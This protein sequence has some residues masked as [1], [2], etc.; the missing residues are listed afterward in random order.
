MT[1]FVTLLGRKSDPGNGKPSSV[2]MPAPQMPPAAQLPPVV[3]LPTVAPVQ[4]TPPPLPANAAAKEPEIDLDNDLFSPDAAQ[5]GEENET[6]RGLL[7]DAEQKIG[8]LESVK[9]SIAK[10]VDPVAS[11]LR[12]YE[13]TKSEKLI[14]QRALSTARQAC[15]KLRDDLAA[16]EKKAATFKAECN[17]LQDIASTAKQN[18]ATLER[19]KTELLAELAVQRTHVAELQRH[20]QQQGT[21]L[22][23]ARDENIGLRDRVA[24][25]DQRTVQLEGQARTAQ[26]EMN[27]AKQEQASLQAALEKALAELAQ[28]ARRLSDAEKAHSSALARLTALETNLAEVQ[29]ERMRLSAALDEANHT[30][31]EAMNLLTSRYEAA[32]TRS[33]LTE[34]LLKEARQALLSRADEVRS[35]ERHV[36]E[37]AATND[38]LAEKLSTAEAALAERE[39]ELRDIEQARALLS[40]QAHKLIQAATARE[41]NYGGARQK[42]REQEDLVEKLQEEL[43]A[44]RG[45]N[46]MQVDN[47][48]AQLQREQL[49]R[50]MAEGALEAAR[51][52]IARLQH[53]VGALRSRS[54][55]DNAAEA[56]ALQGLIRKAA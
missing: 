27:Q 18:V 35:F 50:S 20:A 24:A 26:Q 45:A 5:L 8:E 9:L 14:L 51:K 15:S 25:A 13:E 10:L 28:T 54:Q 30:H 56:T 19:T 21:D 44:A 6:V 32:R 17:R 33:T 12:G 52:D 37:A 47:L 3:P 4:T 48:N 23:L 49:E 39:Q 7:K 16:S 34:N 42:I 43:A 1:K 22:K 36:V 40:E 29:A 46:E 38:A 55:A 2:Q 53:E 11:T 41:A 31:R